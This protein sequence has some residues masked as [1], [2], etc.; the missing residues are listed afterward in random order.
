[1][2]YTPEFWIKT[3]SSASSSLRASRFPRKKYYLALGGSSGLIDL[4]HAKLGRVGA[5]PSQ[6][7][8]EHK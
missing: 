1:M 2:E 3:I 5:R 7:T 4:F 8:L 6:Q